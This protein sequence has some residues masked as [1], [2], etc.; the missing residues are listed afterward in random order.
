MTSSAPKTEVPLRGPKA[1]SDDGGRVLYRCPDLADLIESALRASD[2][3]YEH[4][5]V[6]SPATVV[7]EPI[8]SVIRE[9][10]A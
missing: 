6:T 9:R 8:E 4:L 2:K 1:A 3:D 5:L 7:F 10:S